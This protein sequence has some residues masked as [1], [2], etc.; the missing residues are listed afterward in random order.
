MDNFFLYQLVYLDILHK[1]KL[2]LGCKTKK[3]TM[4]H[5]LIAMQG[6]SQAFILFALLHWIR[7]VCLP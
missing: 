4:H 2:N 3:G 1:I 6:L 5:V 7:V